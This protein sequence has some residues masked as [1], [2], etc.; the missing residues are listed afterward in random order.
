MKHLWLLILLAVSVVSCG[1]RPR[2]I[3][4]FHTNDIHGRFIA[5]PAEWRDDNALTGGFGAL[6]Y[7][8]DSLRSVYPASIYLDAGDLMTGNPICNIEYNG[9]KGGALQELLHRCGVASACIGNHEF[10]HGA[11]PLRDFIAASP[12]PLLCSNLLDKNMNRTVTAPSQI[13]E[14]N[15]LRIGIIGVLIDDLAGVVSRSAIEP[16]IVEN[17]ASSVQR[18]IDRLDPDTDLLIIL[19]HMGVEEDSTLATRIRNA[20]VIIGG[21][22]HTRLKKPLRVKGVLIAQAGSYLKNLGVLKLSVASDSVVSDSGYLKELVVPKNLPQS[23]VVVFADSIEFEIQRQYGQVIGDLTTAW[24]GSYY[25]GSNAG[26]W[27]CDRLRERY[28]ADVAV[29][30]AG[31]IRGGVDPGPVTKLD[32]LQLLPFSNSVVMFQARG[33]DLR[34]MAKEQ[35]RAQAL[36]THGA[37]EFSG[38]RIEYSRTDSDVELKA[39]L[40]GGQPLEN[41]RTYRIVS[42]DYVAV[43]QANRYFGFVPGEI[44]TTGQLLND[45]IIDEIMKTKSPII[46][47]SET[48][49]FEVQ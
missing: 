48:R 38:I 31:G 26:N 3:V 47:D 9:V 37:L 7:Y 44:E 33:V 8:L 6:S 36:R 12:Y 43:S 39:V 20:D 25:S 11:D 35:A 46:A 42:I 10:D 29:V 21:H 34:M 18:E 27:I 2:E 5:E 40:I 14:V 30:N 45:V 4:I 22:S 24:K 17:A 19:S 1:S 16:F 49:T 41:D 13:L 15:G 28:R 32:I 23:D